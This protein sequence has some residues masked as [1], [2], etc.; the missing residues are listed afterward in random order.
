MK[1]KWINPKTVLPKINQRVLFKTKVLH[2]EMVRV[3]KFED[4]G[5]RDLEVT[6]GVHDANSVWGWIPFDDTEERA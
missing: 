4:D 5:F 2:T 6:G 1:I 3:A